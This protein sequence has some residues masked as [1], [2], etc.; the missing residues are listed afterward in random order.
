MADSSKLTGWLTENASRL[1][2]QVTELSWP[3]EWGLALSDLEVSIEI[4]GRVYR[5][6]GTAADEELAL[7][8]A[9][10]EAVERA[11]CAG[12]GIHSVGVAAHTDEN[13]AKRGAVKELFERDAFFSHFYTRTPFTALEDCLQVRERFA[14]I[15]SAASSASIPVRFFR[16]RSVSLPIVIAVAE[17]LRAHPAW[18]GVVGFGCERSEDAAKE[19]ALLECARNLAATLFGEGRAPMNLADFS[20]LVSPSS[21]DRQRL[22]L[23]ISYWSEVRRLFPE[24]L[25]STADA[26]VSREEPLTERLS[27]PFPVLEAAP[28]VVFRAQFLNPIRPNDRSPT[29][30]KRLRDFARHPI[31]EAQLETLPHFLG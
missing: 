22:A 2:L 1:D 29:T 5:G 6:R 26:A 7:V 9:G 12:H 21:E 11:F 19:S 13:E 23:D 30:L 3:R 20:S 16:A 15:F 31:N 8:K 17:G 18:G 4:E 25:I 10:A 27:V 24:T 14:G 28:L